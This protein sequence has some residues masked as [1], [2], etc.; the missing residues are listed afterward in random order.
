MVLRTSAAA[1]IAGVRAYGGRLVRHP[2]HGTGAGVL[3]P[4]LRGTVAACLVPG[5]FPQRGGPVNVNL[6]P[7]IALAERQDGW[8][9]WCGKRLPMVFAVHHR[10]LRSQGGDNS[11]SN[12]VCLC[13]ACHNGSTG[14]VHA[15]PSLSYE[16]GFLVRSWA[17]PEDIPLTSP[18]GEVWLHSDGSITRKERENVW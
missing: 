8:C 5:V 12:L 15:Q 7:R 6:W 17:S 2:F 3:L 9:L 16:R 18:L 1:P 4:H 10:R 14:A 11:A 13:H